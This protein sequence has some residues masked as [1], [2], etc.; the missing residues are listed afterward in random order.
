M[1]PQNLVQKFPNFRR[2]Q[3]R[4]TQKWFISRLEFQNKFLAHQFQPFHVTFLKPSST[5]YTEYV[6]ILTFDQL[7]NRQLCPLQT[8]H[9]WVETME[10]LEFPSI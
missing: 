10:N 8:G 7:T 5:I 3:F 1:V 2:P 9:Q 4:H 6:I